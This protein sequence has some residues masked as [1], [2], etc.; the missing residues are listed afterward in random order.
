[1]PS[2]QGDKEV[3]IGQHW[4]GSGQLASIKTPSYHLD[5]ARLALSKLANYHLIYQNVKIVIRKHH[6]DSVNTSYK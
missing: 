2:L 5:N 6:N 4:M 3:V 1:M